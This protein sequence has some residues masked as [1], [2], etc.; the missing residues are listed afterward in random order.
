M[1]CAHIFIARFLLHLQEDL[2]LGLLGMSQMT[3]VGGAVDTRMIRVKTE[4]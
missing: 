4:R 2:V 3:A 1:Y